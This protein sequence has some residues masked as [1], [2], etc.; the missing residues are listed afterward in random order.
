MSGLSNVAIGTYAGSNM[1][2]GNNNLYL[3]SYAI[4]VANRDNQFSLGNVLYGRDMGQSG[5][6]IGRVGIGTMNPTQKLTI[7]GGTLQILYGAYGSGKVLVS[8][9]NGVA[10]WQDPPSGVANSVSASGITNGVEN[11]VPKFGSG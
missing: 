11:Y 3:G 1:T 4:G 7:S 9:T 5:L 8:D 10:T 2:T 6:T